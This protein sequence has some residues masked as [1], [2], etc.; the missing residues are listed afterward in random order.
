MFLNDFSQF[1]GERI[2]NC[3]IYVS[4]QVKKSLAILLFMSVKALAI[5][6]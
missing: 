2:G 4:L 1:A 3:S 5:V 6:A